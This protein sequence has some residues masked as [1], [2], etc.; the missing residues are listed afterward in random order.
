M[1]KRFSENQLKSEVQKRV[2][3]HLL[4]QKNGLKS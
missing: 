2:K 1:L 3:K 4:A